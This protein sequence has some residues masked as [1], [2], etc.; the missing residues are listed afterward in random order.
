MTV[1]MLLWVR[2]TPLGLP[3]VPEVKKSTA[4]SLGVLKEGL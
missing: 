2:G 1:L 4:S 3:V